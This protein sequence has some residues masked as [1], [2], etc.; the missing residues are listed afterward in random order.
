M[1]R[2]RN[3]IH[4]LLATKKIVGQAYILLHIYIVHFLLSQKAQRKWKKTSKFVSQ[5]QNKKIINWRQT[6]KTITN[7][8]ECFDVRPLHCNFS[9]FYNKKQQELYCAF[10]TNIMLTIYIITNFHMLYYFDIN[11]CIVTTVSGVSD[12]LTR[13][14]TLRLQLVYI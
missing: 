8:F 6:I 11:T 3:F 14:A 7:E 1:K 13:R 5:K 12:T 9:S 4:G 2:W 10:S